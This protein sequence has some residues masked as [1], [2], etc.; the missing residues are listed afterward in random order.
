MRLLSLVLIAGCAPDPVPSADGPQLEMAVRMPPSP[1]VLL[2]RIA[3]VSADRP[4]HGVVQLSPVD[5]PTLEIP[6]EDLAATH[7]IPLLG[8]H[9]ET[10]YEVSATAIDAEG[11]TT[12]V[13]GGRIDAEPRPPI[14]PE[15]EVSTSDPALMEPGHT[16]FSVNAYDASS[17]HFLLV[18]DPTG[19]ISWCYRAAD[20]V[21]DARMNRAGNVL[22]TIGDAI[23]ELDWTG[24]EL[25]RWTAPNGL[26]HE[27]TE[28][29]DGSLLSLS[30]HAAVADRY[31]TNYDDPGP[32]QQIEV[33]AHSVVELA[34]DGGLIEE[35]S[36]WDLL[37]RERIAYDGLDPEGGSEPRD[38]AH[39][40][41]VVYDEADD[42]FLVSVRHQDAVVKFSRGGELRW[43][44]GPH[45]NWAP[46]YRPFL[47]EPEGETEW[48]YHPHAP[49]LSTDGRV[50]VFDNGNRRVNPFD[51][52][53]I[54]PVEAQYSRVVEYAIDEAAMSV[55]QT[56]EQL[57]L[58]GDIVFSYATGDAN[59][60]P[61]TGNILT[62][63]GLAAATN[64]VM[65]ADLGR[66]QAAVRIAE[67]TPTGEVVFEV[68]LYADAT[69]SE[70]GWHGYRAVRFEGL[71]R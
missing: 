30:S 69:D 57:D 55:T 48:A 44:L 2:V 13:Y 54:P 34:A 36:L 7:E 23:V 49:M 64:G 16:L 61:E 27:A 29:P 3:E 17:N 47:L 14:W 21:L 38:W 42:A 33:L 4:V 19:A 9:F 24:A 68:L 45:D 58:D 56:W 26:H 50:L 60:L 46:E 22:A 40:N 71:N 8:L 52:R 63:Y 53:E 51:G 65:N 59:Y 43:I 41:A 32:R 39:A 15:I 35:W 12:E 18:A 70:Q 37:D 67:T 5:G 66:G 31:P 11:R 6:F 20:T 62:T 10:P 1:D 28:M 25:Q